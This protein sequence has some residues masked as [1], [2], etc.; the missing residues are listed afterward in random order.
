MRPTKNQGLPAILPF[1]LAASLLGCYPDAD[2]IQAK[3][4]PDASLSNDAVALFDI[5]ADEPA[6]PTPDASGVADLGPETGGVPL[7]VGLS[8]LSTPADRC[9]FYA[10]SFCA[11]FLACSPT[12]F[13]TVYL[14]SATCEERV[15]LACQLSAELPGATFPN[16]DCGKGFADFACALLSAGKFPAQCYAPGNNLEGQACA[17]EVQCQGRRCLPQAGGLCGQCAARGTWGEACESDS[18]C[19]R[20]LF[21]YQKECSLVSSIGQSCSSMPCEPGLR[22]GTDGN[23]TTFAGEGEAC[24]TSTDCDVFGGFLCGTNTKKCVKYSASGSSCGVSPDGSFLLCGASKTCSAGACLP[25][26][27]LGETCNSDSGPKCLWPASCDS[28]TF[29]CILPTLDATCGVPPAISGPPTNMT[30]EITGPLIGYPDQNNELYR[31]KLTTVIQDPQPEGLTVGAVWGLGTPGLKSMYLPIPVTYTGGGIVCSLRATIKVLDASGIPLANISSTV[32]GSVQQVGTTWNKT[33]LRSGETGY[34]LNI[35]SGTGQTDV[36]A[37][38]TDLQVAFDGFFSGADNVVRVTP[39]SYTAGLTEA[40]ATINVSVKNTGT[41]SA[42]LGDNSQYLLLDDIGPVALGFLS[43][44]SP[45]KTLAP[46]ESALLTTLA[47]GGVTR[48]YGTRLRVFID[49]KKP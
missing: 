15:G 6:I 40:W 10:Q 14:T 3:R 13:A 49:L 22:C 46:G 44:P 2:A 41:I 20:D 28:T 18:D 8:D 33:C 38:A 5:A 17:D 37:N 11:R 34:I 7:P 36:F 31:K 32:T 19:H 39:I 9:R 43:A 16:V 23:C 4:G 29:K 27:N 42:V 1:L 47:T 35:A 26:A 25:S 48:G 12:W 30:A 45:A 24:T 21:C